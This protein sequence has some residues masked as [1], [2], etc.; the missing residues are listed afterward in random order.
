MLKEREFYCNCVSELENL[1]KRNITY[2]QY[3]VYFVLFNPY[4]GTI[5]NKINMK[6]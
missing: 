3:F 6:I 1:G 5:T 4:N 2:S